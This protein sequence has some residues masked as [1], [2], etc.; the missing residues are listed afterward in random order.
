M[1]WR[2]YPSRSG[3]HAT[4]RRGVH[5]AEGPPDHLAPACQPGLLAKAPLAQGVKTVLAFSRKKRS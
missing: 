3:P 1:W 2:A 5:A 4:R